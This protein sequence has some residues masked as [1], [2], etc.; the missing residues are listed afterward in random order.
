[1]FQFIALLLKQRPNCNNLTGLPA[2][3]REKDKN[4]M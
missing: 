2:I 3:L 4:K 1:M